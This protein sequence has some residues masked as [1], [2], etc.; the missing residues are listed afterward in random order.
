[1]SRYKPKLSL[2]FDQ[3]AR[4]ISEIE[5]LFSK[6]NAETIGWPYAKMNK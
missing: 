3:N 6:N 1:M 4:Q 2:T 5:N